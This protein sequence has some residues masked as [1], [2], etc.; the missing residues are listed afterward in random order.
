[1]KVAARAVMTAVQVAIDNAKPIRALHALY[2]PILHLLRFAIEP[3]C[4][5]SRNWAEL[6]SGGFL[7]AVSHLIASLS[8]ES[9]RTMH[10]VLSRLGGYTVY[11]VVLL[12]CH[13]IYPEGRPVLGSECAQVVGDIISREGVL[14]QMLDQ[15]GNRV[16]PRMCDNVRVS[17]S[18]MGSDMSLIASLLSSQCQSTQRERILS[19]SPASR[20]CSGCLSVVYC[21]SSCQAEDWNH[22]HR[23]ECLLAK[24]ESAGELLSLTWAKRIA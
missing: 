17:D 24:Q 10:M 9:K 14:Q 21:S 12:E 22:I 7:D 20:E 19:G 18:A 3:F 8:G 1:L 2:P 11:P 15:G 16:I 23:A 5:I 13:R 6:V 4:R